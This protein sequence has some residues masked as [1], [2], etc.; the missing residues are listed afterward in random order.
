MNFLVKT[1][2]Q[3]SMFSLWFLSFF[4]RSHLA[5]TVGGAFLNIPRSF[6]TD[7]TIKLNFCDFSSQRG[8][9]ASAWNDDRSR[10]NEKWL[11]ARSN[12]SLSV[13]IV[14]RANVCVWFVFLSDRL[15][16]WDEL[17]PLQWLQKLVY[18]IPGQTIVFC[19]SLPSVTP[20]FRRLKRPF[21]K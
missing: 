21:H 2:S 6:H 5:S 3:I 7:S 20:P 11:I 19:D 1:L 18:K 4:H 8:E 13:A 17:R 15:T 12:R 9:F 14:L 10:K 16:I